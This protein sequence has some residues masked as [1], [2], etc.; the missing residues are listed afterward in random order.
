MIISP[1]PSPNAVSVT[2]V[3]YVVYHH[4]FVYYMNLVAPTPRWPSVDAALSA[5]AQSFRVTR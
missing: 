5:V 3:D 4:G 1:S 2:T